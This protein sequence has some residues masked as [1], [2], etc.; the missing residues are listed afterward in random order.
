MDGKIDPKAL[1]T[2]SY[3]L[4]VVSTVWEGKLNGQVAD[5]VMQLTSDPIHIT[6]CLNKNNYTAELLEKSKKFSI[7]VFEQ[8]VPLPFIGNFGFRSGREHDKFA[9]CK[10]RTEENGVPVV[11]EYTVAAVLADLVDVVDVHTHKLFIGKVI[12]AELLGEGTPLTYADYH[13][14]KNGKSHVNAPSAIFNSI[15]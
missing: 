9:S 3:G 4:Y 1:F 5:A 6:A 14:L 12:S 15:K 7:S 2:F 10:Y 8:E 11:T 13:R